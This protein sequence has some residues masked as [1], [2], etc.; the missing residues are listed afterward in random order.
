MG[1][2]VQD[3]RRSGGLGCGEL[4]LKEKG[5][6]ESIFPVHEEL[7]E[8][9]N[10]YLAEANLGPEEP[11]FQTSRGRSRKLTGKRLSR[12]DAFKMIRRR[13]KDAALE[14]EIGCHSWRATGITLFLDAGGDLSTAQQLAG[15][16]DISTTRLYQRF[17][18]ADPREIHRV[19]L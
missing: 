2:N 11:L 6:K 9:L 5:G 14:G 3:F 17:P 8:A 4:L 15:H 13:L 7:A 1:M 10:E 16:S 12:F 19:R 18:G